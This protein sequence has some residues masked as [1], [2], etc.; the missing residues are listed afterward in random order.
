MGADHEQSH[1][2]ELTGMI[3]GCYADKN[4]TLSNSSTTAICHVDEVNYFNE[5]SNQPDQSGENARTGFGPY[6]CFFRNYDKKPG[7]YVM[8]RRGA[9]GAT[10]WKEYLGLTRSP[11]QTSLNL[12]IIA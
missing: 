1:R 2:S 3:H 11:T 5:D 6:A 9:S 10:A 8:R 12:Q 7:D 4:K